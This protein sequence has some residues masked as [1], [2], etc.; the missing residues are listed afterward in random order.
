MNPILNQLIGGMM[1]NNPI[2]N[3][4]RTIMG[5]Q[6]PNAMLQNMAQQNPQLKQTMDYINQNG[7]NAKQ[8]FYSMAQQKGIN[9]D[10][11]LNQLK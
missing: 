10:T 2:L 7:G 8:L 11:I 5:A 9:P 4:Y 6:N 1:K 3:M